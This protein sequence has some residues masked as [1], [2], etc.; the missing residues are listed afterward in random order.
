MLAE[1]EPRVRAR[2]SVL[3]DQVGE[4]EF[5]RGVAEMTRY[6]IDSMS[7]EDVATLYVL[8]R[9]GRVHPPEAGRRAAAV[10][11]MLHGRTE[12]DAGFSDEHGRRISRDEWL[13]HRA[14]R[15]A[16]SDGL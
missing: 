5:R 15:L 14:N 11:Q 7:L 6:R 2:V 12:D 16:T 10:H 9:Q 8:A 3:I 13:Q 1:I 4:V